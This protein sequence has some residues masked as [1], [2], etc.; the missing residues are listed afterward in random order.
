M[1]RPL[2][3]HIR[4]EIILDP[5]EYSKIEFPDINVVRE[6]QQMVSQYFDGLNPRPGIASFLRLGASLQHVEDYEMTSN[7]SEEIHGGFVSPNGNLQNS[8]FLSSTTR[9]LSDDRNS[10]EPSQRISHH[11]GKS[12]SRYPRLP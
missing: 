2:P 9:S 10:E 12:K 5:F 11:Q 6:N 1:D 3:K 8:G 4:I 7:S